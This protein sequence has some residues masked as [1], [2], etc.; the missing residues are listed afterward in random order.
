MPVTLADMLELRGAD[1]LTE[2]EIWALLGQTLKALQHNLLSGKL[3]IILLR[4]AILR[5]MTD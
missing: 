5:C 1:G 2:H 3:N 4:F